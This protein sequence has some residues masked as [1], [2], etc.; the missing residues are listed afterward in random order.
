[1]HVVWV[2]LGLWCSP[3]GCLSELR[4]GCGCAYVQDALVGSRDVM[5]SL[6]ID[7]QVIQDCQAYVL[8][9]Q[10]QRLKEEIS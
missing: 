3:A 5:S 4:C 6:M 8:F 10:P 7:Q 2:E 9:M 1:M